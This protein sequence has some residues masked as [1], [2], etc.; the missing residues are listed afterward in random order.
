M[1]KLSPPEKI[2]SSEFKE[3]GMSKVQVLVNFQDLEEGEEIQITFSPDSSSFKPHYRVEGDPQTLTVYFSGSSSFEE[4]KSNESLGTLIGKLNT[5]TAATLETAS[6]AFSFFSFDPSSSLMR[7]SQMMKIYCRFRFLDVNYGRQLGAYFDFSAKKFDPPSSRSPQE[8]L[9]HSQKYYGNLFWKKVAL[10]V[11][12]TDQL[13]LSVFGV[14]WLLKI[15]AN[16]VLI[17]MRKNGK[18][19]K[20]L[21]HFVS[22]SQKVHMVAVNSISMDLIP[23]S[24]ITLFHTRDLSAVVAWS[25]GAFLALL[26]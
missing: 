21:A 13:R 11:Y 26:V 23:Y 19:V 17:L 12:E 5:Y 16:L 6:L 9:N 15:L 1:L 24:L 2:K 25:S 22:I 10:T 4:L 18:V 3:S 8:I 7:F 20:G 14:S